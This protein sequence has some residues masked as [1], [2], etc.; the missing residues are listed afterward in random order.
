MASLVRSWSL[1]WS[2]S[3]CERGLGRSASASLLAHETATGT[4]PEVGDGCEALEQ[5]GDD[6][7][8]LDERPVALCARPVRRRPRHDDAAQE[9]VPG[10]ANKEWAER[11]VGVLLE[12][13]AGRHWV[14]G[15]VDR[16]DL[17][18]G[19]ARRWS[20]TSAGRGRA[21]A[22]GVSR[23]A[24][25]KELLKSGRERGES[26]RE[27]RR[28]ASRPSGSRARHEGARWAGL[29]A[30]SGSKGARR[31]RATVPCM[32][33]AIRVGAAGGAAQSERGRSARTRKGW[34]V[35]GVISRRPDRPAR[36]RRRYA[37]ACGPLEVSRAH[38]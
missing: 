20:W 30:W 31:R 24:H 9:D 7:G 3:D 12:S 5:D 11:P 21:A 13:G 15:L 16:E 38:P 34:V 37:G 18:H 23:A 14:V 17:A 28:R 33:A 6:N 10:P 4:H 26:W 2:T 19:G 25:G 29:V 27:S 8:E 36:M 22:D 1:P 35:L 32:A